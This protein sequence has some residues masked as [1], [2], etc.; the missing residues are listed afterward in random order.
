MSEN[1]LFRAAQRETIEQIQRKKRR[2][3]LIGLI[4]DK[5]AARPQST[6]QVITLKFSIDKR[7]GQR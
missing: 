3:Q 6:R 7:G 1:N 2:D 5:D 4:L